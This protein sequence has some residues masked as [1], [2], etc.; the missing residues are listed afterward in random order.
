M[1]SWAIKIIICWVLSLHFL[2][3]QSQL[4]GLWVGKLHRRWLSGHSCSRPEPHPPVSQH[5]CSGFSQLALQILRSRVWTGFFLWEELA[6]WQVWVPPKYQILVIFDYFLQLDRPFRKSEQPFEKIMWESQHYLLQDYRAFKPTFP[7]P[8]LNSP[9]LSS[10]CSG[11][12][13]KSLFRKLI[14]AGQSDG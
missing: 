13:E 7:G 6:A 8:K 2:P 1:L 11:S 14:P 4:T 12:E 5:W 10:S 9:S 3:L